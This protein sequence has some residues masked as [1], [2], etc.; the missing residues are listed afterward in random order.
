MMQDFVTTLMG[1]QQVSQTASIRGVRGNRPQLRIGLWPI[2]SEPSPEIAMGLAALIGCLM[3][4]WQSVRVYRLFAIIDGEPNDF[5][6]TISQSQFEVD[7]WELDGLD[8]NVAIWGS[9]ER[10]DT[11][12]VLKLD[13]ENDLA[14]D[15]SGIRSDVC[16]GATLSELVAKLPQL[17]ERI[18]DYL[19]AGDPSP[20]VPVYRTSSWSETSIEKILQ[21][22]FRWELNL[23]LALWGKPWP[24]QQKLDDYKSLLEASVNLDNDLGDWIVANA[25]RRV[26]SPLYSPYGDSFLE[27]LDRIGPGTEPGWIYLLTVALAFSRSGDAST[28]YDLLEESVQSYPDRAISWLTFAEIY[29]QTGEIGSA[30]DTFQ[31]AIEISATSRII[32]SR[33]AELLLAL[34][35]NNII[36]NAGARRS[37]PSGHPFVERFHFIE[38]Q[39]LPARSLLHEASRAYRAALELEPNDSEILSQLVIVLIDL[40][41]SS[42]WKEFEHLIEIDIGGD[43]VRLV[44]EAMYSLENISPGIEVL[45]AA[46]GRYPDRADVRLNLAYAYL[47]DGQG[48]AARV[49]LERARNMSKESSLN[50]EV[51]R[52]MLSVDDPDFETRFG[53]VTDMLDA[54]QEIDAE[55]VE[56]LEDVVEAAPSFVEGYLLLAK[57]YLAWGETA[58]A[59]EILLD[60]QKAL[61]NDPDLATLLARTLWQVK[62]KQMAFDCLNKSLTRNPNHVPSLALMGRYLFEDGQEDEARRFL[63]RAE[64]LDPRDSMLNDVRI[65]I[66]NMRSSFEEV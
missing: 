15:E 20:I 10:V 43:S 48:A 52:L 39:N 41:A 45:T 53:E 7:D 18:A 61:P 24:D 33:Y 32:Y 47:S 56:F 19:D 44:L 11:K 22:L 66:A 2:Q 42:L 35:A 23:Y 60:G 59:L 63:G 1:Y 27:K 5:E 3:E 46:A 17:V 4:R 54:G 51:E 58:D 50:T 25:A 62:E 49:E 16:E 36:I 57:A 30:I 38:P 40:K 14:E 21:L 28:A 65:F 31:R 64:S 9:L 12:Y 29:W 34:D 37:T 8:E 26:L 55:D 6:W 13:I